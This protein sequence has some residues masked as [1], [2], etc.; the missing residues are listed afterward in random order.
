MFSRVVRASVPKCYIRFNIPKAAPGG[1][2][3]RSA[4]D[5]CVRRS[6]CCISR[7]D[8]SLYRVIRLNNGSQANCRSS[9]AVCCADRSWR[10]GLGCASL[11][12]CME[13]HVGLIAAAQDRCFQ[14]ACSHLG[15]CSAGTS[16]QASLTIK[17][18]RPGCYQLDVM[19]EGAGGV[20]CSATLPSEGVW[21]AQP[22]VFFLKVRRTEMRERACGR[23]AV[24]Y[25]M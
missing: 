23:N 10:L 6:S 22:C 1:A 24:R 15:G 21:R 11:V 16:V 12:T 19:Q 5:G 18:T 3:P 9:R 25:Q 13:M 20:I 2:R 7:P 17:E 8:V 14:L 4:R